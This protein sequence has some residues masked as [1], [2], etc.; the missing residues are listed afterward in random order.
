MRAR[1]AKVTDIVILVVA[2]DDGVMPQTIEAITHA[3]AAKVPIVVALNKIDKPEANPERVKQELVAQSVVPE[4]WG[5]DT[6]V[7]PGLGEDRQGHRRAARAASCCRPRCSSSRRRATRRR[8]A[9]SSSRASTRAAARSRR[10]WCSRA[11]SSAATSCSPARCSAACARCSTRTASRSHERRPVDP[12]R[13]PGPVRRAARGRGDASCW[14]TSARRARSRCSARASSATS[15]SRS[16][17]RRSS[18]TCS[19]RWARAR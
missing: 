5:G 17:R 2:A 10:C 3:K 13:D 4:E 6:H 14:A 19:S 18:R 16:S 12:G 15:S 8:R 1:G 7:R 11:R 9:S